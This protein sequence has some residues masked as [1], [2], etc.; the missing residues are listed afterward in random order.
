VP[1]CGQSG[2]K[3]KTCP[4][5]QAVALSVP[6][7]QQE[8]DESYDVM[9]HDHDQGL[10]AA[11]ISLVLPQQC[12]CNDDS[13]LSAAAPDPLDLDDGNIGRRQEQAE[14]EEAIQRSAADMKQLPAAPPFSDPMAVDAGT[15]ALAAFVT[16]CILLP[17]A[18]L[19]LL[20][21]CLLSLWRLSTLS[22][23]SLHRV[24]DRGLGKVHS[25]L[26]RYTP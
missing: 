6:P 17:T 4:Q 25:P 5:C 24:V 8:A 15:Q 11:Q 1:I 26:L 22:A 3:A 16:H 10:P 2:H 21:Q 13:L 18:S 9:H 14:I 23:Y 20:M 19:R 7:L 12:P